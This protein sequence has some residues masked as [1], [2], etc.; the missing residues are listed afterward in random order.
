MC[1]LVICIFFVFFCFTGLQNRN[2]QQFEDPNEIPFMSAQSIAYRYEKP[3]KPMPVEGFSSTLSAKSPSYSNASESIF[4]N[5]LAD[6]YEPFQ[7]EQNTEHSESFVSQIS[8][9]RGNNIVDNVQLKPPAVSSDPEYKQQS[10][11][12]NESFDSDFN[13]SSLHV[14]STQET[15]C[16]SQAQSKT[17]KTLSPDI[18]QLLKGKDANT[19]TNILKTLSPFYPA[20]QG[21]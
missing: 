18:L 2:L 10:D 11:R 4:F 21:K 12:A 3:P 19:V 13:A 17:S 9:D 1:F 15:S 20:L 8:L 6:V 5:T 7:A 14:N 16:S